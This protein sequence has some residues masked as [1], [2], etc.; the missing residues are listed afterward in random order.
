[1]IPFLTQI[2][3]KREFL[4]KTLKAVLISAFVITAIQLFVAPHQINK[5]W[6][7]DNGNFRYSQEQNLL[8]KQLAYYRAI[9]TASKYDSIYLIISIPDSLVSI[10]INGVKFYGTKIQSYQMD[11]FLTGINSTTVLNQFQKPLKSKE[12]FS[13]IVK[14]PIKV[15]IAPK[16][17]EEAARMMTL[18]DSVIFE[19]AELAYLTEN[20]ISLTLKAREDKSWLVN[21]WSNSISQLSDILAKALNI[22][23]ATGQ[24][25][26]YDY[27]PEIQL[28]LDNIALTSIYRALPK[29]PMIVISY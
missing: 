28:T 12:I 19:H 1:M 24:F 25:K 10:G 3:L 26:I 29:E 22:T 9:E 8:I 4:K 6:K 27:Q 16:N 21:Q 5:K 15:K 23:L 13:S 17:A 14:E 7:V 20:G 11:K 18:P 2:N